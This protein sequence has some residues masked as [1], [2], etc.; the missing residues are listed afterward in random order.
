MP[1]FLWSYMPL[2]WHY[3]PESVGQKKALMVLFAVQNPACLWTPSL[4]IYVHPD[5]L[6]FY[7][8]LLQNKSNFIRKLLK[9]NVLECKSAYMDCCHPTSLFVILKSMLFLWKWQGGK[10]CGTT[11]FFFLIHCMWLQWLWFSTSCTCDCLYFSNSLH[12]VYKDVHKLY[13]YAIKTFAPWH[14]SYGEDFFCLLNKTRDPRGVKQAL[15]I[16][17]WSESIQVELKQSVDY[18]IIGSIVKVIL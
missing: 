3:R 15:I 13:V 18:L 5:K 17:P 1:N 7:R 6:L 2:P 8:V 16:L 9:I 14:C 11:C 4:F 10:N 12:I